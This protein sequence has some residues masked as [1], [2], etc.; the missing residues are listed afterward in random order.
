MTSLTS[1]GNHGD[2]DGSRRGR[3]LY[4]DGCQETDDDSGHRIRERRLISEHLASG[5]TTKKP[6]C[7]AEKTQRANKEVQEAKKEGNFYHANDHA[8]NLSFRGEFCKKK[9]LK[10]NELEYLSKYFCFWTF[11]QCSTKVIF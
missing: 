2:H 3:A 9:K 7:G 10:M 5:L 11:P 1:R 6:K 4:Q 8:K